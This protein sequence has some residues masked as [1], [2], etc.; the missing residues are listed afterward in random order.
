MKGLHEVRQLNPDEDWPLE[1]DALR[2]L[3]TVI[4]RAN[5]GCD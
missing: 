4:V 1:Q 3:S 2:Q 5:D